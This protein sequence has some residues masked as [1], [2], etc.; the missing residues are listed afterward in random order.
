[1]L[2]EFCNGFQGRDF[3]HRFSERIAR[4]FAKKWAN[5]WFAQKMSDLLICSFLVSDLTDLLMVAHFWWA[6]WA[7]RSW[8]LIFDKQ[9]ERFAHIAHFLW[10]TWAICLHRSLKKIEWANHLFSNKK[11]TKKYDFSYIFLLQIAGFLWAKERMSNSLIRSFI[12]SNLS[13]LLTVAHLSW[14]TWAIRSRSI[15][16]WGGCPF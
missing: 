15:F 2:T 14:G 7:N 12:M 8:S 3:A 5:E 9:P 4:F 10:V 13:E 1:M 6:T 11:R 16:W